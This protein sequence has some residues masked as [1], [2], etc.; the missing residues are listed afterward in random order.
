MPQPAR[1]DV[2]AIG[3]EQPGKLTGVR[4]EHRRRAPAREEITV[5]AQ[6]REP[7]GVH[8]H[9]RDVRGEHLR[10]QVGRDLSGA[11]TWPHHPRLHP[12]G[13]LDDPIEG[14]SPNRLYLLLPRRPR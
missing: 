9:C 6:Q 11:E 8:P 3:A 4:G 10:Q 7:V 13:S 5:V 14:M 1:F 2:R 12:A